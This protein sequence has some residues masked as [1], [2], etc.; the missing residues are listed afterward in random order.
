MA[1]PVAAVLVDRNALCQEGGWVGDWTVVGTEVD[2]RNFWSMLVGIE[3]VELD[4]CDET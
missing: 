1:M 3:A 2:G 4:L